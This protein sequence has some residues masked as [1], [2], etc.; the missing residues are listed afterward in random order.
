VHLSYNIAARCYGIREEEYERG[1]QFLLSSTPVRGYLRYTPELKSLECLDG[2]FNII[3][4][5]PKGRV[6]PNEKITER[7]S[8]YK[9]SNNTYSLVDLIDPLNNKTASCLA[10]LIQ[11]KIPKKCLLNDYCFK[12]IS[13]KRELMV[14]IVDLI[15]CI[16]NTDQKPSVELKIGFKHLIKKVNLPKTYIK[17][18]WLQKYVN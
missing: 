14:S 18:K 16:V 6:L 1:L 12:L 17:N 4:M 13:S 8:S 10:K 7:S 9:S 5:K 15:S 3:S 11:T 2:D